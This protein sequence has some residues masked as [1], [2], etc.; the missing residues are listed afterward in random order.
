MVVTKILTKNKSSNNSHS[1]RFAAIRK[2]KLK[3]LLQK[4]ACDQKI[5]I[6]WQFFLTF[7]ALSKKY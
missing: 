5:L 6:A 4:A 2:Q 3:K 7:L 1:Y